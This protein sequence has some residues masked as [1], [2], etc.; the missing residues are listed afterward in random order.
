MQITRLQNLKPQP[1]KLQPEKNPFPLSRVLYIALDSPQIKYMY[2]SCFVDYHPREL[3]S[4]RAV[5]LKS[6][7]TSLHPLAFTI[8]PRSCW[9]TSSGLYPFSPAVQEK[10][11]TWELGS[12]PPFPALCAAVPGHPKG[13]SKKQNHTWQASL[14]NWMSFVSPKTQRIFC[15]S[16]DLLWKW[17]VL[18]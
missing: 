12:A 18:S 2:T 6:L 17:T 4:K 16:R 1:M 5:T 10:T 14:Q 3:F 11:R 8:R 15:V 7:E 13:G 9:S